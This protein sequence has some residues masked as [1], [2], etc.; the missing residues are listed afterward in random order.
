MTVNEVFVSWLTLAESRL[1]EAI[2]ARSAAEAEIAVAALAHKGAVDIQTYVR[3]ALDAAGRKMP[4]LFN[5]LTEPLDKAVHHTTGNLTR[6]R[7]VLK[8]A[9]RDIEIYEETLIELRRLVAPIAAETID[10]ESIE[11][12]EIE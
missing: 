4:P 10:S 3:D 12:E 8:I 11:L 2:E 7:S 6:A 5:L 1:A 9:E